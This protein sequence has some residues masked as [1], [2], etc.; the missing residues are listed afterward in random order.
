MPI[1]IEVGAG[2]FAFDGVLAALQL[3][4]DQVVVRAAVERVIGGF[5]V[6][7]LEGALLVVHTQRHAEGV[8][9]HFAVVEGG[10]GAGFAG[11][12]LMAGLDLALQRASLAVECRGRFHHHAAADGIARHV[13]RGRLDHPQAL[14]RVGGNHVQRRTTR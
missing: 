8:V 6:V 5:G 12:L 14:G 10:L 1:Q 4:D 11:Q 3:G 7:R 9:E 13:R 2:A